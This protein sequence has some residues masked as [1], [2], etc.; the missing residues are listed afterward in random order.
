MFL[1]GCDVKIQE[2]TSIAIQPERI[3]VTND[4]W[5]KH[6]AAWSPDGHRIAFVS[7][8]VRTDLVKFSLTDRREVGKLGDV[9]D[10]IS[11]RAALSFDGQQLAYFSF[12]RRDRKIFLYNFQNKTEKALLLGHGGAIEPAWSRDG[13]WLAYSALDTVFRQ[14]SIWIIQAN[15][16]GGRRITSPAEMSAHAPTWSP[17]GA[18]LA[19]HAMKPRFVPNEDIWIAAVAG[20]ELRQLTSNSASES[21]PAW[22]P[23]GANIAFL[24]RRGDTTGFSIIPALGGK[25]KKL[26][27]MFE[28]ADAPSW[29]P[30]G[31]KIAFRVSAGVGI[32]SF[33][34]ENVVR[35]FTSPFYYPLWLPDGNTIIVTKTFSF[36]QLAVAELSSGQIQFPIT[37]PAFFGEREPAWFPDNTTIAFTKAEIGQLAIWTLSLATGE[38]RQVVT[39]MPGES[40]FQNTFQNPAISP[41]GT[42]LACDNGSNIFLVSTNSGERRKLAVDLNEPLSQPA[43]SPDNK[44]LA[45]R[46]PYGLRIFAI[47]ADKLVPEV[48][49]P[50]TFH[51]P[52]WSVIHPLLGSHLAVQGNNGIYI[53]SPEEP[54]PRLV[55]PGGSQPSWAPD[56]TKLAYIYQNEIY[57]STVLLPLQ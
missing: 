34:D 46:T 33:A 28:Y 26:V 52:A 42:M 47:E 56:G 17:D 1:L 16:E 15:G 43:W 8:R 49:I 29:S 25:E 27:S 12:T 35:F 13:Q 31:S 10:Q 4:P 45:C 14:S 37:E 41:D 24:W 5:P 57:I 23:D 21:Y 32:Y 38:S 22:S 19:F 11:G 54:E 30:D 50:G 53:L 20:G 55:V 40:T 2:E 39:N 51:Y 44:Q 6:D 18:R 3:R 7:D 36:N 48:I 9:L